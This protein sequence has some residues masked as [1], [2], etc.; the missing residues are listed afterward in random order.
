[1]E[2]GHRRQASRRVGA[3]GD[4]P[5]FGGIA[6]EGNPGNVP[7]NRFWRLI[8][9]RFVPTGGIKSRQTIEVFNP[10]E[11]LGS[12]THVT[13]LYDFQTT[14]LRR[15]YVMV[16]GCISISSS[17]GSSLMW[18][19]HDQSPTLQ[20]GV[21]YST[22]SGLPYFAP[23]DGFLHIGLDSSLGR[24]TTVNPPYGQEALAGSGTT[25][26]QPIATF[27]GFSFTAL[28]AFDGKLFGALDAGAGSKIITWD[29]QAVRDDLTGIPAPTQLGV[30]RNQLVAGFAAAAN[31]IRIRRTG[32]TPGTWTT[33]TPGAGT[34]ATEQMVSYKDNLYITDANNFIW[35]Y[36]GATLTVAHAI[37]NAIMYGLEA[38]EGYLYFSYTDTGTS[39]GVIGRFD[40]TVWEDVH[41]DLTDQEPTH[42]YPKR[43]R[44]Y[45]SDLYMAGA[46]NTGSGQLYVSPDSDTAGV[47][48]AIIDGGGIAVGGIEDLGAF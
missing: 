9:T 6:P 35:V 44:R 27:P 1:M 16:R 29:G 22:S 38:F 11:P 24:F 37:V 14:V 18:W 26:Q 12:I 42:L 39:H 48:P 34:I 30:W 47:W 20:R 40:G 41:K 4:I 33:V 15:L 5:R 21:Y 31:Q 10:L 19:D 13:S 17:V 3:Q 32:S 46:T 45:R 25:Q 8:N 36:D 28:R 43:L 23:F 2:L 7:P